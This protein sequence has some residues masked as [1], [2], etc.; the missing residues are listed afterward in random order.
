MAKQINYPI[1]NEQAPQ[2][3]IDL[4][5]TKYPEYGRVLEDF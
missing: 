3:K 5:R 1:F 2:Q 4:A